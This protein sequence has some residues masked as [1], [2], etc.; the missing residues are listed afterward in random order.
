MIVCSGLCKSFGAT[1]ALADVT[2]ELRAG[3][4]V[5][6]V[7]PSG[8]GKT[9]L[10]RILAGLLEADAGEVARSGR[11]V[12]MPQG[13]SLLPWRRTLA[14]VT[15]GLE[16]AGVADARGRARAELERFGLAGFERRF[17]RE[18]SGGMRQRAALL[19]SFLAPS[20][21]LLLD[22]PFAALDALTRE[23]LR[24]WLHEVWQAQRRSVLMVTHDVEEA[25]FLADR[26]YV[27]SARPARVRGIVD[28]SPV[29]PREPEQLLGPSREIRALLR[30]EHPVK[31]HRRASRTVTPAP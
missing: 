19:R 30:E 7:G 15:V 29:R 5:A 28:V 8:C 2:L 27:L 25:A 18:L 20:D 22:E 9:T 24:E 26:V 23:E 10:L 1:A 4:L 21:A 14:N 11:V 12:Y 31:G 13:D 6:V 3:E 16:L 17:P